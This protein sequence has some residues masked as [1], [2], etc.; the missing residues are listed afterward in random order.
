[1]WTPI[2]RRRRRTLVDVDTQKHFF[3]DDSPL[4]V[5]NHIAVLENVQRVLAWAQDRHIHTISTVQISSGNSVDLSSFLSGGLTPEKPA[6]TLC[7]HCIL[8]EAGDSTDLPNRM[9]ETYDQLILQKRS[10]DPFVEPRSDRLF[11]EC[12]ADEFIIIGAPTEGAVKATALGLLARGKSV[13]VV[14]D[15]IGSLNAR[16]ARKTLRQMVTKGA[17][18]VDASMLLNAREAVS[19]GSN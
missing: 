11:T 18:L 8:L 1:M 6:C 19:V 16:L 3:L 15:A 17:R 14:V 4:R 13:T 2:P 7:R 10:F 12:Q 9:M 5:N